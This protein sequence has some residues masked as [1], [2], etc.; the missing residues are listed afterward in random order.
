[1]KG[2][3]TSLFVV[4]GAVIGLAVVVVLSLSKK[5]HW[6]ESYQVNDTHPYDLSLLYELLED[7]TDQHVESITNHLTTFKLAKDKNYFFVANQMHIDSVSCSYLL[8]Y[9]AEGGNALIATSTNPHNLVRELKQRG[10]GELTN[11]H[12]ATDTLNVIIGSEQDDASFKTRFIYA[13]FGENRSRKWSVFS[14][15]SIYNQSVTT[16][17]TSRKSKK[18]AGASNFIR[19]QIGKGYLFLHSNPLLFTNYYLRQKHG[20]QYIREVVRQLPNRHCVWDEYNRQPHFNSPSTTNFQPSPLKYVLSQP[21]LRWAWYVLLFGFLLLLLFRTKREQRIIPLLPSMENTSVSF[22]RS[23][24]ALYHGS[25]SP[26]YIALEMMKLF[27]NYNRR[28]YNIN[29]VVNDPSIGKK[30]AQKSKVSQELVDRILRLE[31]EVIYN[32]NAHMKQIVPLYQ[33]LEEYYSNAKL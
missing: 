17:G 8:D 27:N 3:R 13:P 5:T 14:G 25:G 23:L 22:A 26:K 31:R 30:I 6:Q 9:I 21:P 29:R 20:F 12:N 7:A 18:E 1:M 32:P 15:S 2:S 4:V 24:G 16:L 11:W 33:S 19:I 10:F 28:K